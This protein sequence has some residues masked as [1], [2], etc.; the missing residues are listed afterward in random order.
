MDWCASDVFI[1]GNRRIGYATLS[2]TSEEGW[3]SG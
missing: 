1:V 2:D 3:V